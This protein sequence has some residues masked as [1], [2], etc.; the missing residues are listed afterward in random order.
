M[1]KNSCDCPKP[2][3]GRAVC[4]PHQMAICRVKDGFAVAE[5]LDPP[6]QRGRFSSEQDNDLANWALSKITGENRRI[7]SPSD[8]RLLLSGCR[9]DEGHLGETVTFSLPAAITKSV[10]DII[11]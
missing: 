11:E 6:E 9:S 2:P 4:E 1:T 5:C 8:I 10:W 7:D 3:G